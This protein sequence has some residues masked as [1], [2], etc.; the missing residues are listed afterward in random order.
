MLKLSVR[1]NWLISGDMIVYFQDLSVKQ[2]QYAGE[3]A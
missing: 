1:L 2:Q 3:R